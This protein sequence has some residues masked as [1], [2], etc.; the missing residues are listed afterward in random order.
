VSQSPKSPNSYELAR[1]RLRGIYALA[2]GAI[3]LLVVPV[4]EGIAL[5]PLGYIDAV[6][7]VATHKTFVPLVQW[8]GQHPGPDIAFHLLELAPFLLV[9]PLPRALRR[10]LP[11]PASRLSAILAW[12]GQIGFACYAVAL[13]VGL[14]ATAA[15]TGANLNSAAD[16]YAN[17]FAIQNLLAHLAGG[18]LVALCLLLTSVSIARARGPRIF[19]DWVGFVALL[20]SALLT[21]TAFQFI[22]QPAQVEGSLAAPSFALLALWFLAVGYFLARLPFLPPEEKATE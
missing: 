9:F 2:A 22:G 4:Y 21:A 15:A 5:A 20:P 10:V 8:I 13:L 12:A 3:L 18:L 16:A 6:H 19:P 7:A 1:V 17:S 11:N 14:F